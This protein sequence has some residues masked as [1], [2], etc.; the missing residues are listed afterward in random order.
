MRLDTFDQRVR[1][2]WLLVALFM[3]VSSGLEC[4]AQG[5]QA[6]APRTPQKKEV[7]SPDDLV[8]YAKIVIQRT[9]EKDPPYLG[10]PGMGGV[11]GVNR[12]LLAANTDVDRWVLQAFEKAL[13]ELGVEDVT[14]VI[15]PQQRRRPEELVSRDEGT[16][17]DEAVFSQ[18]STSWIE[19]AAR[20]ADRILNFGTSGLRG[21]ESDLARKY[22]EYIPEE[23]KYSLNVMRMPFYTRYQL[24]SSWVDYPDELFVAIGQ[25]VWDKFLKAKKW[26]LTD[27]WGT[28]LEWTLDEK[29]WRDMP[30]TRGTDNNTIPNASYVHPNVRPVMNQNPDV[31]GVIVTRALSGALIPEIRIYIEKAA[32]THVEAGGAAGERFRAALE[33]YKNIQFPGFA[34]PGVGNVEEVALGVHPKA[35]PDEGPGILGFGEARRRSGTIHIGIGATRNAETRD[36]LMKGT[37]GL[38]RGQHRDWQMYFPTL[39][40]DGEVLVEKGHLTVLDDP[41]IRRLAS[42]FGDP[43]QL[44][45]EDWIPPLDFGLPGS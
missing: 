39:I 17:G 2:E 25:K 26:V 29:H 43:D 1:R 19:D 18:R 30:A 35:K 27:E 21:L 13:H 28:H 16:G 38:P 20:E 22:A 10:I 45:S 36:V 3:L 40:L 5:T 14:T 9:R 24:A 44:L 23:R 8:R 42:K 37:S 7:K 4:L 12:V 33:R 15:V 6:P 34:S 32:V 31:T 41:E 11:E